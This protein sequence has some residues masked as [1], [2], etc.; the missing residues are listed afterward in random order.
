M[1]AAKLSL[2]VRQLAAYQLVAD[3]SGDVQPCVCAPAGD[4]R[5]GVT[6]LRGQ[7]TCVDT[8]PPAER[9]GEIELWF[10]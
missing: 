9:G 4:I 8:G 1:N 3:K 2:S 5:L 10:Q 6:H 7:R